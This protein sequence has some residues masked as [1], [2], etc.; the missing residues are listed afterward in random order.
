MSKSVLSTSI[1]KGNKSKNEENVDGNNF[2]TA[3][4]SRS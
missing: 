1:N 2:V 3:K 4:L